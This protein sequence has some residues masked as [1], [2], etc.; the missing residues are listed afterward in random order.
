VCGA[1]ERQRRRKKYTAQMLCDRDLALGYRW[2][3][4]LRGVRVK[5]ALKQMPAWRQTARLEAALCFVANA[6]T[7]KAVGAETGDK[8]KKR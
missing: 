8:K 4:V 1:K 2:K 5:S 6:E 7:A 3:L